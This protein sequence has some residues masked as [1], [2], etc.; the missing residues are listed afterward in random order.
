[1]SSSSIRVEEATIAKLR[2]ISKEE[3]K[4]MGQVVTDLVKRYERET[5]WKE[6]REAYERLREDPEAWADYQREA[7]ICQGGSGS[8]LKEEEAYYTAEELAEMDAEDD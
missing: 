3:K 8:L 2:A 5:F 6:A 1:M 4:P 7:D